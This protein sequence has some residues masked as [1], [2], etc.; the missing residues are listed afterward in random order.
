M[1][2]MIEKSPAH[3]GGGAAAAKTDKVT[4]DD[5]LIVDPA[6]RKIVDII[7]QQEAELFCKKRRTKRK[8]AS[9]ADLTR[10]IRAYRVLPP[11]AARGDNQLVRFSDCTN[12]VFDALVFGRLGCI[13]SEGRVHVAKAAIA[14][15]HV[16]N[17]LFERIVLAIPVHVASPLVSDCAPRAVLKGSAIRN[18]ETECRRCDG[19]CKH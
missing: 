18:I 10:A 9:G 5:I 1:H 6:S 8:A 14:R 3:I 13:Q 12:A 7:T 17:A 16:R 2:E 15:Q 4:G 19:N 11:C